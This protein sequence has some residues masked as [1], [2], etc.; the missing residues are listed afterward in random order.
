MKFKRIDF[1]FLCRFFTLILLHLSFCVHAQKDRLTT[2]KKE[3]QT[4][5]T[6]K[7]VD[8][9]QSLRPQFHFT[10]LKNW[11]ND[12]NGMVYYDGEYHQRKVS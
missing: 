5:D 4:F 9:N 3:F 1:Q 7:E 12:P 8:Y 10:S 2:Q 11:I 6:Y